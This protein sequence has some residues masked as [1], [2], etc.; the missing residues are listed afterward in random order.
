VLLEFHVE[1]PLL[2]FQLDFEFHEGA[3]PQD[4]FC[5]SS[6]PYNL[7]WVFELVFS[8]S[9]SIDDISSCC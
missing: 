1:L 2:E 6:F 5:S 9:L 7:N 4:F 3:D 8:P